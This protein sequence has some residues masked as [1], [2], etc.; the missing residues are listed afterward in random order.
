MREMHE[1]WRIRE[2]Y[3]GRNAQT[4]PKSKRVGGF[5]WKKGVWEVKRQFMSRENERN[6]NWFHTEAI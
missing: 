1:E 3:K 4:R 6:E 5:K 2:A